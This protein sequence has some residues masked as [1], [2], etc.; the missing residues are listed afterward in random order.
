MGKLRSTVAENQLEKELKYGWCEI[1]SRSQ[2]S[3]T[4]STLQPTLLLRGLFSIY[5]ISVK[6]G[7]PG[8][9]LRRS[10]VISGRDKR[11]QAD[12]GVCFW[13]ELLQGKDP[14]RCNPE[15]EMLLVGDD[16]GVVDEV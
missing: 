7:A 5:L 2:H 16:G 9:H 8:W 14:S 1:G 4:L 10:A 6:A 3:Q 11:L 12:R 15:V 13:Y